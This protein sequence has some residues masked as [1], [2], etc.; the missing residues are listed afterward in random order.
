MNKIIGIFGK[1]LMNN[2]NPPTALIIGRVLGYSTGLLTGKGYKTIIFEKLDQPGVER[3]T[4]WF[5]FDAGPTIVTA[6]FLLEELWD[7]AVAN[8]IQ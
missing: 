2:E 1:F 6:P 7:C 8:L 3:A 5:T 4:G